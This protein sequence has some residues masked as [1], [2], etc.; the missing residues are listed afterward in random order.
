MNPKQPSKKDPNSIGSLAIKAMLSEPHIPRQLRV[1]IFKLME[2]SFG[3]RSGVETIYP[4]YIGPYERIWD[5]LV[6]EF[7]YQKGRQLYGQ[8]SIDKIGRLLD[9]TDISGFVTIITIFLEQAR[10]RY[11]DPELGK[12]MKYGDG[13]AEV[14]RLFR[15]HKI[16]YE[17]YVDDGGKA[18]ANDIKSGYLYRETIAKTTSLLT[19]AGFKGPLEEFEIANDDLSKGDN[20]DAIHH[21]HQALDGTMDA[22]LDKRG[23]VFDP[24]KFG[25]NK[26]PKAAHRIEALIEE[27]ILHN[28]LDALFKSAGTPRNL[29][30]GAGHTQGPNSKS[31]E[32]SCASLELHLCG[33][34]IVYLIERYEESVAGAT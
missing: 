6:Q 4:T 28:S 34:L 12:T 14:N 33:T 17:F 30:P 21:A 1:Q 11:L 25:K 2:Y 18:H 7:E 27:G 22:I 5:Q 10:L 32:P 20:K 3:G 31:L 15:N 19:N 26:K 13:V 23:Y 8:D 24:N 16:E 29:A 9:D